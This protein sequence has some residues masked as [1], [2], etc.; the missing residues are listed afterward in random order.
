MQQIGN[1]IFFEDA[2]QGV[3]VGAL[4]YSHGT[5]L[6]DAPLRAEDTRSWR[7]AVLNQ[8]SGANRLLVSL[9]SHPDRTLGTRSLECTIVA[10]QKAAQ[11]FRNRP[12]I[13]K[14]QTVETG[15]FWETYSDAIGMRWA[16]PDITFT[17]QLSLHWGGPE[18]ILEHRPGPT[19]GSI[20]VHV[21]DAKVV[22]VGDALTL[23]QPPFLA[24][25]D[26]DAWL[27]N[28]NLLVQS[29]TGYT[30]IAGRG[31]LAGPDDILRLRDL[32]QE[33]AAAIADL[34]S[35]NASPDAAQSL[36]AGFVSR[37]PAP[38]KLRE[39]YSARLRYG[40][41]HCYSRRFHPSSILGTVEVDYEEQ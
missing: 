13:F 41:Y 30:V 26:L 33:I 40:M 28:L 38:A 25:A 12:T 24:L 10:H 4:V 3:T 7:A 20:W 21:P 31:G 8:R 29:Y 15:S 9:D 1:G 18:V 27:D 37:Y 14:G 11:V 36:A 22:F 39:L 23:G 16:S 34:A 32:L 5:I 35:R 2:Y 19:P 17:D 6:L